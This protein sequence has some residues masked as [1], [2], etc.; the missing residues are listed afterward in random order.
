MKKDSKKT[1]QVFAIDWNLDENGV[2]VIRGEGRIPDCSCGKNPA[3]PWESQKSR[4]REVHILEGITEIGINAFRNCENLET[5]M[6]PDSLERIHAY[7][8]W[9]CGKL[10]RMES[11]EKIFQHI[12]DESNWSPDTVLFGLDSFH[13]VPWSRAKWGD[14][15]I[16]G[17][18]LYAVFAP[19]HQALAVPQ[20]VRVLKASSMNNLNAQSLVLPN[21][22]EVI[23]NYAFSG[24]RVEQP[25]TLPDSVT[26]ISE[27]ALADCSICWASSPL[28]TKLVEKYQQLDQQAR[29]RFPS[30]FKHYSISLAQRKEFGS[31]KKLRISEHWPKVTEDGG[32][33]SFVM[34]DSLEVGESIYRRILNG[35]VVLCVTCEKGH[36]TCVKSFAYSAYDKMPNEY[37]MY[38]VLDGEQG[39]S[40]WSDS[41][42]YQEKEDIVCAFR[43]RNGAL[44]KQADALRLT[45]PDVREEWFWSND[46]GNFGGPLELALLERWLRANPGVTVDSTEENRE[47]SQYRWFVDV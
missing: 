27:Y 41:F 46:R 19:E 24:S 40:I 31:F 33:A 36:I 43:N 13:N 39:L 8:F 29:C 37:L 14:F 45:H 2:L 42:T 22:L 28:L 3:A 9:G 18:E 1:P 4:I 44:L 16:Q 15:Y 47:N 30:F 21:T 34:D 7:A 23:E 35:S 12:Y 38:P 10:V 11:G 17:D 20:G 25:V 5:V 6:L 32:Y 26:T